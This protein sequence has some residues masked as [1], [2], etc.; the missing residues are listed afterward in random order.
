MSLDLHTHSTASDGVLAPSAIV[1][2]ARGLG[3]T[4][5]ALCDHDSVDGIP[6]ALAA[7]RE[8][9]IMVI[10]GVE[11]SAEIDGI[12]VHI[13]GY[14]IDHTDASLGDMLRALR[15]VRLDRARA[16][17]QVLA[18][19]GYDLKLDD[20]LR[21][22]DGGSVGRA[23]VAMALVDAGHVP[24]MGAAFARFLGK[25]RPFYVPKPVAEPE[26]VIATILQAGDL[27]SLHIRAS[28][29]RDISS[30]SSRR[31]DLRASRCTTHN[32]APSSAS[33]TLRSPA[34]SAWSLRAVRTST[35]AQRAA[36]SSGTVGYR[37]RRFPHCSPPQARGHSV[38][39]PTH[40]DVLRPDV[41]LSDEQARLRAH[42]RHAGGASRTRTGR[43]T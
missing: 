33:T 40:E 41:R 11:L 24:S 16:I 21:F 14:F 36:L 17:V 8:L 29:A 38:R 37:T 15:E 25:G 28:A 43:A 26:A 12:S 19:A 20:V 34:R 22:T 18:D 27:R 7:G 42:R 23:H 32:T 35:G 1:A 9:D 30:R 3:L 10:P 6:E 4:A 31:P 2:A 5:V 39:G 13:L